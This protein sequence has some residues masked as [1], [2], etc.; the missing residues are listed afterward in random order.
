MSIESDA[1]ADAL[2]AALLGPKRVQGDAGE[3]EMH[4]IKDLI[5]VHRYLVSKDSAISGARR[6]IRFTKLIP[7][8][9]D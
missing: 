9:L 8:G 4:G 7:P 6:G 5:M 3:V 1:A 2:N